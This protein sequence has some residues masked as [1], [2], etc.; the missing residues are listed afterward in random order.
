MPLPL[1]ETPNREVKMHTFAAGERL[2]QLV[3]QQY[4]FF[5]RSVAVARDCRL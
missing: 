1:A 4:G 3:R 2:D 5:G